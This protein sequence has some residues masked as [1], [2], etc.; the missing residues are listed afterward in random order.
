M[1]S[2]NRE[3]EMYNSL[4]YTVA[5]LFSHIKE[6]VVLQGDDRHMQLTF[7]VSRIAT[8]APASPRGTEL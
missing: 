3:R 4:Q 2:A 5:E 6:H 8:L 7:W 1:C